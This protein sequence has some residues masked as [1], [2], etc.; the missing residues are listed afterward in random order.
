V[1]SEHIIQE[2][3]EKWV[4]LAALAAA[5][6]LMARLRRQYP[7]PRPAAGDFILGMFDE[8]LRD[9]NKP[10]AMRPAAPFPGTRTRHV[11]RRG[12]ADDRFDVPRHQDR[13]RALRPIT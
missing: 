13:R 7:W 2:M 4:F 9:N 12:I 1:A 6:C 5:T 8:C 10:R 11:H 3:W